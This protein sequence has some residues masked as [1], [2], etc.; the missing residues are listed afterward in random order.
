MIKKI[1]VLLK[2][3]EI[4]RKIGYK[5]RK[6]RRVN[7]EKR[8]IYDVKKVRF[9]FGLT[10]NRPLLELHKDK[11]TVKLYYQRRYSRNFPEY[12]SVDHEQDQIPDIAIEIFEEGEIYPEIVI[13]D[14]KYRVKGN[15]PP[16]SAKK[17]L[18]HYVNMIRNKKGRRLVKQAFL[19]YP[20]NLTKSTEQGDYGYIGLLPSED[21]EPFEQKIIQMVN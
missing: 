10:T 19:V 13:I 18:S 11:K 21:I 1:W 20:G 9:N 8:N 17:A 14:P 15:R 5:I 7:V 16:E 6:Q 12:G 4:L 2:I 3:Y